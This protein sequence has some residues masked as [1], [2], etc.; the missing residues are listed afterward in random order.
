VRTTLEA[1]QVVSGFKIVAVRELEEL[2]ASGILARHLVSGT[3]VFHLLNDDP[4]NLFS[5]AFATPSMDSTGVAH[6]LEHSVLCGSQR[7]P[8]KDAFIVLAQGSLQTFLN[9]MTFPDKTVYPAASVNRRDYFNLLSVYGDAVFRPLLTEATFLQEGHR[10]GFAEDR[11][12]RTGVVYNEM[13]GN[14]SS[15]DAIAGDWAFRSVLPGTPYAFDSGGDPEEIPNLTWDDLRAFHRARYAPA[16]CRIFLCGDI[17]T[18]D[19]LAFLDEHFLSGLEPGARSPS[20]PKAERWAEP[21]RLSVPYPAAAGQKSTV[22]LSWLCSD[23]TDEQESMALAVLAETLLGHD[24]SPL[25]R[26]LVESPL[27]EDLAPA[28]GLEADLRETVLTIGLRGVAPGTGDQLEALILKTLA[29]LVAGGLPKPEV[30]AA[31]LAMEFSNREIR[32][33]GGPFSL[34]WMRRALRGWMHGAQPWDTLLFL[35]AFAAL[36]KRLAKEPRYLEGLIQRYLLDNPHRALVSVDAEPGL[37]ERQEATQAA[38][39]ER[40][41]LAMRESDR[42]AIRR[43]AAELEKI[44]SRP[45]TPADLATIPHISRADL[46]VEVEYVPRKLYE[47]GAVPVLAH[48]LFTNGITYVDFG[49]PADVLAPEDYPWLP[50]LSR[51]LGAL[52]LPG[53]DY[54]QVS[55]LMARTVGGFHGLLHSSSAAPGA[56]RSVVVPSGVLDLVGRDWL[57]FRLKALDDKLDSGLDLVYR[58]LTESD[59]TD[60]RRLQDLVL[61]FRNDFNASLAPAGHSYAMSRAGRLFSR[62]RSVEEIWNGI[63]QLEFLHRIAEL[64]LQEIAG[65]LASLRDRLVN[66]AGLVLNITGSAAAIGQSLAGLGR[67]Q[68]FGPPRPRHAASDDAAAFRSPG[69]DGAVE[70]HAS[71]SLQVGFAALGLKA[72]PFAGA[73]QAAELVL[74]HRLSTG[75]LWEDIRMKGGAYG[76]F[77]FPD[78]LEP[79]FLLATYRDPKPLRSLEAFRAAL[80]AAARTAPDSDELEKAIIGSYAKETRP[81]TAADKGMAD[82][83]RFLTGIEDSARRRKLQAL[84]ALEPPELS[85]A[86][87]RLASG[88]DGSCATVLAGNNQAGEAAA[89]L[90]AP[91]RSLPV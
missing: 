73:E 18:A 76:A 72:A 69:D 9:A 3:E 11:L 42:Q 37:T 8:L 39:L 52:G 78:G 61:E 80:D 44:Q 15:M 10:L 55:S 84:V 63:T 28:T 31:L 89:A 14:Y 25:T 65:R 21:R 66:A 60:L 49:L 4:E 29:D 46:A 83:L 47:A 33:A 35:P 30:E 48:D 5:F 64:P 70:V 41:A 13:K 90:G 54:G 43:Q 58:L 67:F 86:A 24:G 34:V 36:K 87:A 45:D 2:K 32:R 16:N 59:F 12:V 7:Y 1:G 75:A 91:V 68:G 79:V 74:A 82:F 50:L 85:A 77:A 22:F 56:S 26:I 27:G 20:P 40:S 71:A 38:E 19:Q 81:R 6:I 51:C 88:W 57:L 23:V 62:S 53:M 17:P